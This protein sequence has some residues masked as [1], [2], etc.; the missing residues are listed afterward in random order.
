MDELKTASRH[1]KI[2]YYKGKHTF[3]TNPRKDT[4]R[5]ERKLELDTRLSISFQKISAQF[6]VNANRDFQMSSLLENNDLVQANFKNPHQSEKFQHY[7]KRF[8][9]NYLKSIWQGAQRC[10]K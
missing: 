1:R 10:A 6:C 9:S 3:N 5:T 7:F 8:I 2:P 4:K